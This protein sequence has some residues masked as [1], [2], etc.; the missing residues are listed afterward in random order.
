MKH[1]RYLKTL[2]ASFLVFTSL[3]ILDG[4]SFRDIAELI[5]G[6]WVW[7]TW[8]WII[9]FSISWIWLWDEATLYHEEE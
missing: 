3:A 7:L 5:I 8:T 1:P 4:M 9:I 6:Y 2:T